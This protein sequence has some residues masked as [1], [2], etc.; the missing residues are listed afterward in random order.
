LPPPA[1]DARTPDERSRRQ[2]VSL[3][4]FEYEGPTKLRADAVGGTTAGDNPYQTVARR[5]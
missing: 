2:L 4:L 5:K 3:P 1:R